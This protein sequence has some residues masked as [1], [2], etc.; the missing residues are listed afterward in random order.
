MLEK[1]RISH[2]QFEEQMKERVKGLAVYGRD[3]RLRFLSL[4]D[5]MQE[6]WDKTFG[7]DEE[8]G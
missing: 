3:N 5:W 2:M 8:E 6:L 4:E 1:I 7:S